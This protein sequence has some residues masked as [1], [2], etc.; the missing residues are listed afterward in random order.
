MQMSPVKSSHLLDGAVGMEDV[1]DPVALRGC[2]VV[3]LVVVD[4]T[5]AADLHE[6]VVL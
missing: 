5:L 4:E 6:D 2:L 3:V 1:D